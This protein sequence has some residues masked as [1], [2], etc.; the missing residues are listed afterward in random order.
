[1]SG[2]LHAGE[3][4]LIVGGMHRSGTSLLASLCEGAG[5]RMGEHLLGIGGGGN[6]KGR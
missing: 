1:M 5:V 3:H 6:P 2:A 4:A